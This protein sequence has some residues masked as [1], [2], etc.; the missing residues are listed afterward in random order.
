MLR[1]VMLIDSW[2]FSGPVLSTLLCSLRAARGLI[3]MIDCQSVHVIEWFLLLYR[4]CAF[5]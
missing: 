2:T 5:G 4:F 1:V 3:N